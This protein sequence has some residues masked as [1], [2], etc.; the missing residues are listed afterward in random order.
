MRAFYS[1]VLVT[2]KVYIGGMLKHD[3]G[4][5]I[6]KASMVS[7]KVEG[8][9]KDLIV[10]WS[11]HVL[12]AFKRRFTHREVHTF[13]C[14]VRIMVY[15]SLEDEDL[16][17]CLIPC[18]SPVAAAFLEE[19]SCWGAERFIFTG[20]CGVLDPA[21]AGRLVVPDSAVIDEGTSCHYIGDDVSV[22][23]LEGS[24][25]V[26]SFMERENLPFVRGN[27]WTTDAVYRETR[28]MADQAR[29]LGCVCVDMECSAIASV[30]KACGFKSWHFM[31]TADR[32]DGGVWDKALMGSGKGAD[33]YVDICV[34]LISEI[35]KTYIK[36]I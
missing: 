29:A 30:C 27:S 12:D 19:A 5:A 25:L 4:T 16:G 1:I 34:R 24:D 36:T 21:C 2:L 20:S 10:T 22:V 31:Y 11:R 8:F 3:N 26:A 14:G 17:I 35:R 18:G 9:P 7:R 32:L 33:V 23:N 28:A 13:N 6:F 15:K